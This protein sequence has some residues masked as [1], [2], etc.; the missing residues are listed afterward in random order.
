MKKATSALT[1]L[2][3]VVMVA[4]A[5]SVFYVPN[6]IVSGGV[7]GL[8]T[9]MFYTVGIP[10]SV[11]YAAVNILLALIGILVLGKGFI[12]KSFVP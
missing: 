3:G 1:A 4:F 11:T 7:S 5:V 8:S 10:T 6:K 2:A 9:I 12:L